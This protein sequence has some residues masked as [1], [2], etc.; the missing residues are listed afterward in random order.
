M[1]SALV[2]LDALL[3]QSVHQCLRLIFHACGNLLGLRSDP[4]SFLTFRNLLLQSF[5]FS[6]LSLDLFLFQEADLVRPEM[7]CLSALLAILF[8][9]QFRAERTVLEF[10]PRFVF[11]QLLNSCLSLLA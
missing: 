11:L 6:K 4:R 9:I 8:L 1:K 10:F 7:L 3:I 2:L 5:H